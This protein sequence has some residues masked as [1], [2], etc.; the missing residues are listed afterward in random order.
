MKRHFTAENLSY[1]N[2]GDF[3]I[4][5]ISV[6]FAPGSLHALLGP[7][8]SGKSTLLKV[9][10]GLLKPASGRLSWQGIPLPLHDRKKMGKILSLVPQ[11]PVP[12]FDYLV[13]EIVAMGRYTFDTSYWK[14]TSS[15]I[16]RESLEAVDVLH[17]SKRK[18]NQLSCGELQRVYIARAL[19]TEAPIL[20][21]DEPTA[22]LDVRHQMEIW[23]LLQQ[24]ADEGKVI[25][26]ATHDL[27]AAEHYCDAAT[28]L[29]DG[30][31]IISGSF[32]AVVTTQLLK[33]VFGVA[34]IGI[35]SE[36]WYAPA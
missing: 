22:N 23:Q 19:V 26:V 6:D 18:T 16:V 31:K 8:G 1:E 5:N 32:S 36:H 33:Q 12:T 35:P 17:L 14:W 30:R 4:E 9:L 7:N 29:N 2:N 28:L 20:L 27:A 13:E 3:L 10:A 21:L 34:D 24:L 11:A 15:T 25:A